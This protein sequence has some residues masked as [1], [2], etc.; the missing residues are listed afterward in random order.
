MTTQS[1]DYLRHRL[2]AELIS[3]SVW[4]YHVFSLSLRDVEPILAESGVIMTR[5]NI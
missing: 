5:A 4:V 3:R 2:P 1:A